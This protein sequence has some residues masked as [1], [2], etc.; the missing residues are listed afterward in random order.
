MHHHRHI[1]IKLY[2]IPNEILTAT[3]QDITN[4]IKKSYLANVHYITY[5]IMESVPYI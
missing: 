2:T 5:K 1:E 3:L 4:A